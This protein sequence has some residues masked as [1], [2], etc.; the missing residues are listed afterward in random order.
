MNHCFDY[1]WLALI[2]A[3]K[4]VLQAAAL[5]YVWRVERKYGP[6]RKWAIGSALLALGTLLISAGGDT[7]PALLILSRSVVIYAGAYV[8]GLGIA[9]ACGNRSAWR[10][11]GAILAV[12]FCGHIWFTLGNPSVAGRLITFSS[13]LALSEAAMGVV[14]L[15]VRAGPL[16]GTLQI[17]GALLLFQS[18]VIFAFGLS[19]SSLEFSQMLR[20][21]TAQ[22]T[23]VLL[24]VGTA[25]LLVLAL[26]VLTGQRT[27]AL[28]SGVLD[29][30]DQGVAMFDEAKRLVVCNDRYGLLYGFG[31]GTL[32]PGASLASIIAGRIA[33][34]FFAGGNKQR[35]FE[36]QNVPALE[37]STKLQHLNDG[38]SI[39]VSRRP[40]PFG[41]WLTTHA[42]VSAIQQIEERV[43]YLAHHDALTGLA[44]RQLFGEELRA[45]A[46]RL[47]KS[48]DG[49]AI[50]LIDLD[51]FKAINDTLGHPSGDALLVSVAERLRGSVGE[52]DIVARLGGDEF[53]IIHMTR[54]GRDTTVQI[55]KRLLDKVGAAYE[56]D[57]QKV[58]IGASVGIASAPDSGTDVDQ[59][60]R[61]ADLALYRSKAEGRNCYRHYDRNMDAVI[62]ARHSLEI[63]LR[64]SVT[65]EDFMLE[66][67]PMIDVESHCVR[68]AEALVRWRHPSGNI[69][70]PSKFIGIAEE[71]GLILPLGAWILRQACMDALGW[72]QQTR[73]SVNLSVVQLTS[74]NICQTVADV[75]RE[76][77]LPASRLELEVTESIFLHSDETA[78]LLLRGLRQL[79]V[80]VALDDFGTGY[81]SL[82]YLAKF[83]FD[84]IKIDKSFIDDLGR[85]SECTAIVAAIIGVA[86]SLDMAT[87][88]EGVETPEQY[89]LLRIAGCR[90][91]QGYLFGRPCP[92]EDLD[93]VN[94]QP[95]PARH[96]A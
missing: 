44:N 10:W 31:A 81:S 95:T 16:R 77:G 27:T 74:G 82:N 91:M 90:E 9:D 24:N 36:E 78:L 64:N 50:L 75:L 63:A 40:M 52:R 94:K 22:M 21:P 42:D 7:A 57:G 72:P 69:V 14:A 85:R 35:Y 83:P 46:N 73:V 66:Y 62:R 34:G 11:L 80:S 6:A 33:N 61:N 68:A 51:R 53:A 5:L 45:A 4:C 60:M 1:H 25:F 29:N 49:F 3:T 39:V 70:E 15:R 76:T 67:Q 12:A 26:A 92:V 32:K 87:T 88:A 65:S 89:E 41:G 96:V 38:R 84:R 17:L 18:V 28:L 59:L 47:M 37:V 48:G 55:A 23:G 30:L 79:G 56:I 58:M 54:P 8:F 20:T 43:A 93:F 71:T 13:A 19:F 86:R 2:Y